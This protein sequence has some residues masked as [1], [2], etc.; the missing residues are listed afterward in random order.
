MLRSHLH[1][2]LDPGIILLLLDILIPAVHESTDDMYMQF[3]TL[4]KNSWK[5]IGKMLIRLTNPVFVFP[6]V[7]C[8]VF[9]PVLDLSLFYYWINHQSALH[10]YD[11]TVS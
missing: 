7:E 11:G 1:I 3:W 5:W 8:I 6:M 9:N 10:S 2:L 4:S